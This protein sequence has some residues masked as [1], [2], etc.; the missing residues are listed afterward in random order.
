MHLWTEAENIAVAM[1]K[2]AQPLGERE[3]PLAVRDTGQE[4]RGRPLSLDYRALCIT[5]GTRQAPLAAVRNEEIAPA[6]PAEIPRHPEA[7]DAAF[8]ESAQG[9]LGAGGGAGVECRRRR[10]EK[11]LEMV[12][13]HAVE[14]AFP[15]VPGRVETCSGT[16][17]RE[18]H[19]YFIRSSHLFCSA[20]T[21]PHRRLLQPSPK[22]PAIPKPCAAGGHAAGRVPPCFPR[23][24]RPVGR[25]QHAQ[26]AL[27]PGAFT[28]RLDLHRGARGP[29]I[30]IAPRMAHWQAAL[31]ATK[32]IYRSVKA[33][34]SFSSSSSPH[35]GAFLKRST[36]FC[37]PPMPSD[38]S[39][40][41]TSR[42]ALRPN[43]RS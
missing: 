36:A 16:C 17:A 4:F 12:E 11:G 27:A 25:A 3:H 33:Y 15:G 29:R 14:R 41:A 1:D 19:S 5:T 9:V 39:G 32:P 13:K 26:E 31:N 28:G 34:S 23:S 2:V 6:P 20:K 18:G 21:S 8:E 43:Q 10:C 24:R 42:S 30:P 38:H 35:H 37:F 22:P 40:L 7:R